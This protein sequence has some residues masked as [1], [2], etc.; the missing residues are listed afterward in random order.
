MQ[1]G[2]EGKKDKMLQPV[3]GSVNI[4]KS[5]GLCQCVPLCDVGQI[6]DYLPGNNKTG[7][8]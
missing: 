2:G 7:I 1:I 3:R 8:I 4:L 5:I 6:Y